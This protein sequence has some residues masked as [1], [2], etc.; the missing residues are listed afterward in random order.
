[1]TEQEAR[2]KAAASDMRLARKE[3]EI[4]ITQTVHGLV[5]LSYDTAT[6][7]YEIRRQLTPAEIVAG[8]TSAA[9]IFSGRGIEALAAVAMLYQVE[10]GR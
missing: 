6:G 4:M 9:V 7:T 1:M 2:R 3:G 10:M 8:N 5:A